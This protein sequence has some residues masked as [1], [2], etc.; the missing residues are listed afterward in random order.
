MF[1]MNQNRR[2]VLAVRPVDLRKSFHGLYAAAQQLKESPEKGARFVF[3]SRPRN[4]VK[5]RCFDGTGCWVPTKRLEKGSFSWPKSAKAKREKMSLKPEALGLLL[6][7]VDLRG[8]KMRAWY[9][10]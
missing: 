7:G 3:S 4:R 1:H 10:R 5:V 9:E 6:D 2:V 8:A